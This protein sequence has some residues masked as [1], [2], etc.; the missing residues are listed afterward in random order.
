LFADAEHLSSAMVVNI[1]RPWL[2]GELFSDAELD[3]PQG[4]L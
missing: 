3:V 2:Y 1:N 4:I